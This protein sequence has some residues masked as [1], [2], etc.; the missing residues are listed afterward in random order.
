MSATYALPHSDDLLEVF[1]AARQA[2]H[3]ACT[4]SLYR[5]D[6]V[7]GYALGIDVVREAIRHERVGCAEDLKSGSSDDLCL[8]FVSTE[9][10]RKERGACVEENGH[11]LRSIEGWKEGSVVSIYTPIFTIS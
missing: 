8:F 6:K 3:I 10:H 11:V 9:V 4:A 5:S 1:S 2:Q 7:F